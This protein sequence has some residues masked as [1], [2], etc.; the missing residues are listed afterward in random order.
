MY[1]FAKCN[2]IFITWT[3]YLKTFAQR[4]LFIMT[5]LQDIMKQE[6]MLYAIDVKENM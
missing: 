5:N 1:I 3:L 4:V 6:H 2:N